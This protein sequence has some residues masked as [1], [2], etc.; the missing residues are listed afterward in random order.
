MNDPYRRTARFYDTLVE[1][2]NVVLRRPQSSLPSGSHDRRDDVEGSELRQRFIARPGDRSGEP[3]LR[4]W[5]DA[6]GKRNPSAAELR[7]S[8]FHA[9]F[10]WDERGRLNLVWA[11]TSQCFLHANR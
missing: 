5:V 11:G 8:S 3:H 10:F 9:D 2:P 6:D 4:Q 7:G 1:P